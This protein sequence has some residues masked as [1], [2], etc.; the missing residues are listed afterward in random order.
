MNNP[1][2]P[3]IPDGWRLVPV[4]AT[5]DIIY[6]I[7]DAIRRD[8]PVWPAAL[9]AA[10]VPPAPPGDDFSGCKPP[11][12]RIAGVSADVMKRAA[13]A[14]RSFGEPS[15]GAQQAEPV[16]GWAHALEEAERECLSMRYQRDAAI[17]RAE[18]AGAAALAPSASPAPESDIARLLWDAA[19]AIQWHLEPNSPDEHEALMKRLYAAARSIMEEASASPAAPPEPTL[20][21]EQALYELINK[22]D[23]GLDTGDI[24]A[25]A[26]RA[27][28]ALDGI[29]AAGDLVTNAY[30]FFKTAGDMAGH[31]EQ[32]VDF[33]I[34]WNACLD[35]IAHA[36]S[37]APQP[38]AKALTDERIHEIAQ[39]FMNWDTDREGESV[40][41]FARTL[42][43]AEQPSAKAL[44]LIREK[45]ERFEACAADDEGCDIGRH[46]LDAL[47]TVGFL[48]RIQ[49]APAMWSLT[50]A[51]EA[52][53]AAE[54]PTELPR[55][56]LEAWRAVVRERRRQIAEEGWTPE[57]DD[58]HADGQLAQAAATY[59]AAAALDG[60]DASVMQD[61]GAGG[62]PHHILAMWPWD[63]EWWKPKDRRRNLERAG[64]LILAEL[65]RDIRAKQKD[66]AI[67]KGDSHA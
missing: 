57:H 28:A 24:L 2:Y 6:A 45:L 44:T 51:G 16:G 19:K 10:P 67:A 61:S 27:S 23:T 55:H 49:R 46:W 36:R 47:T 35:A 5:Q 31:Y 9:A 42:L 62:T 7:S 21:Y 54:Q 33:R 41:A 60:P 34:G 53:L 29:L 38:S 18:A 39:R 26:R 40:I 13:E 15:A 1:N 63:M 37:A 8:D 50:P 64:A 17:Q 56:A 14:N 32:S 58:E 48:S 30:D 11:I 3:E 25:D 59:A 43:A 4:E 65:E 22:I 66:A 12:T 20:P 52:V